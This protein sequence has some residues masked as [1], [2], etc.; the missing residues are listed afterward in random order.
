MLTGSTPSVSSFDTRALN[1]LSEGWWL[2]Q[3]TPPQVTLRFGK[4]RTIEVGHT[5]ALRFKVLERGSFISLHV[6]DTT[7]P[8]AY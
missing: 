5:I 2:V 7:P 6:I 1:N 4:D 8:L 3:V